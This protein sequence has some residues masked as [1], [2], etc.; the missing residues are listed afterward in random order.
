[1]PAIVN[2]LRRR[3]K[4]HWC[5]LGDFIMLGRS[6]QETF[7]HTLELVR[8]LLKLGLEMNYPKFVLKPAQRLVWISFE[9]NFV[10]GLFT[11][12]SEQI[13]VSNESGG[14]FPTCSFGSGTLEFFK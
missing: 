5:Y 12:F 13:K 8:L 1:M 6:W 11:G 4:T 3:E 10:L 9:L 2:W 7:Y 14:Y